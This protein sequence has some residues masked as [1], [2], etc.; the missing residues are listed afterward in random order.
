MK[1]IFPDGS[2][3]IFIGEVPLP[4]CGEDMAL[5]RVTHGVISAGTE[6]GIILGCNGKTKEE[7]MKMNCRLGYTGAGIVEEVKGNRISVKKGDRVA[8]YGA[9]YT[10]HSE[11]VAVP[12]NLVYRIPDNLSNELAT[13]G[14]LGAIALHGFRQGKPNLG[15]VCV[16]SG[17][18]VIGN[19]CAQFALLAG[20]RVIASDFEASRIETFK[21][22]IPEG[23]DIVTT[24]PDKLTQTVL[25]FTHGRGADVVYL[26]MSTRSAEPMEQALANV[27]C[28]G[29][30]VVVGVLDI[31]VPRE[32]LF[33]KE[34]TLTI[35]RAAG[36]GRYD[37]SYE[38]EGYDY[39]S[40]YV[41]WTE[42]RNLEECIRLIASKRLNF[43]H[44]IS[45]ECSINDVASAYAS[46]LEGKP[47]LGY[48]IDWGV[49]L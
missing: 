1:T 13:F 34:A 23:S 9:P 11:Y 17:L 41:R 12:R 32:P 38:R 10:T 31:H 16:V 42:G 40:Q 22:S 45:K 28:G 43:S 18:G 2:N 20:C 37:Q 26:C 44:L 47:D 4:E 15:E 5:C 48:I 39:P 21:K 49:S 3:S 24:S 7:I 19:L 35:S 46:I 27:C 33:G 29:K 8:F 14:G 25:D 30:I 36:P 6:R